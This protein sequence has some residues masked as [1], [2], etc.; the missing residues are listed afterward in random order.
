V[1]VIIAGLSITSSW[2]NGHATNYRALAGAL[3]ALGHD[4]LFLERNQP[5][6]AQNR[7]FNA[8]WVT[9]Y[10]DVG[11][12]EQWTD[13]VRSA[14]LVIVGSFVPEGCAVAEWVLATAGGLAAFWDLDTPVTAAKLAEGDEEYV[15]ASL[16]MQFDLYLSFTGGPLLR[17][18]GARR[19][20]PFYC[21]AD[22][23]HYRPLAAPKRWDLGYLGTYSHDRQP[24][25]DALL[26][27]PAR[28][29]RDLLFAVAGA[30]YPATLGWPA[31]VQRFENLPP[32]DHPSFYAAQ[33]FTLNIT[34]AEMVDAGWSPSV[35]L[36]EA[37]ACGVPVISDW[38]EGLD[39]FFEPGREILIAEDSDEVM[40]HLALPETTRAAIG[41]AARGRVLREH[42]ADRRARELIAH[43]RDEVSV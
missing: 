30:Q 31:N 20:T 29:H 26:L 35:R 3:R 28:D 14:D 2:G 16:L 17:A 21:L 38:W 22:T 5:W 8:A 25:L 6:Y 42:S 32:S 15:S 36:F 39:T 9:L 12:L 33:R 7:D 18:L 37:G 40:R 43:V 10:D 11:E 34:R 13:D 23:A 24:K 1:R 27:E 4:V 41:N 19:P